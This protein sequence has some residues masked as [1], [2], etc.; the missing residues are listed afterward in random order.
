MGPQRDARTPPERGTECKRTGFLAASELGQESGI[1]SVVLKEMIRGK[2]PE[3]GTVWDAN[4][5][6]KAKSPGFRRGRTSLEGPT[7]RRQKTV[8]G[9]GFKN[10]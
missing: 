5:N 10:P 7:R 2:L 3:V 6:S 8:P 1:L 9:G 4:R